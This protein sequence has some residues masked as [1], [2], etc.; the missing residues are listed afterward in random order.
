MLRCYLTLEVSLRSISGSA[1]C[2]VS[3]L[4]LE[5]PAASSRA[6]SLIW[7]SWLPKLPPNPATP[8]QFDIL[9]GQAQIVVFMHK[10][11]NFF[12]ELVITPPKIVQISQFVCINT[13]CSQFQSLR[14]INT[15]LSDDLELNLAY[16]N[17]PPG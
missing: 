1:N 16:F 6:L 8:I 13:N 10:I 14:L 2:L 15:I 12:P 11:C 9:N 4:S 5:I 17:V 7:I 3:P